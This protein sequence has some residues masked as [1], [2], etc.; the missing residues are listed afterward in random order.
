VIAGIAGGVAWVLALMAFFGPAQAVL[1]DPTLQSA[2]F[3]SVMGS[4]EPLPRVAAR[5]WI[6]P[7]GILAIALIH[8]FVYAWIRDGLRGGRVARGVRFGVVAWALMA[9]WFEFYLP[10]NVM[11]EPPA[12]VALELIL[13]LLVLVATGIAIASTYE[14]R[15]GRAR[16]S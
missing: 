5:P 10:W 9:P 12:L 13:W 8:A 7:V 6:L 15:I 3:L 1:A 2:K 4:I 16:A 14:W 11:H